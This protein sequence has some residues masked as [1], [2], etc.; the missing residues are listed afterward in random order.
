MFGHLFSF[1]CYHV[2]DVCAY[3]E[4]TSMLIGIF[5]LQQVTG[6]IRIKPVVCFIKVCLWE[7]SF[8]VFFLIVYECHMAA[9]VTVWVDGCDVLCDT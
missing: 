3:R 4:M 6:K 8:N 1:P 9:G 5:K 7:S 2:R